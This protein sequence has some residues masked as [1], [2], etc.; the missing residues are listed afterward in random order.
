MCQLRNDKVKSKTQK[1]R[2]LVTVISLK[3]HVMKC[4]TGNIG[5]SCRTENFRTDVSSLY[6]TSGCHFP[7]Y[8]LPRILSQPIVIPRT[9]QPQANI[10]QHAE[11]WRHLTN[12]FV[13]CCVYALHGMQ[14]RSSDENSV[15]LFVCLPNAWIVTKRKKTVQ[16]F[17]PYERS[18][19]LVF[20]EKE[21]LVT[22]S[23]WNFGSTGPRWSDIADF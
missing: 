11:R 1:W 9:H 19:S 6:T 23:T 2:V 13:F 12:I 18:F 21:C 10:M 8:F 15:R 3:M 22:P 5:K 17:T 20:W 14:T 4:T 7:R 16:I